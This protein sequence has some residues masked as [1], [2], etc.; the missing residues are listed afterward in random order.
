M[1]CVKS[2]QM[3]CPSCGC[4]TKSICLSMAEA[5]IDRDENGKP[6]AVWLSAV[7]QQGF[8]LLEQAIAELLGEDV[9]QMQIMFPACGGKT[10]GTSV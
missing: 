9:L 1:C 7:K 6:E 2:K 4:T 3:Q 10:E 8:D 5:R